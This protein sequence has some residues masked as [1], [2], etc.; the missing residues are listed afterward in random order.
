MSSAALKDDEV[1][2][3]VE[4]IGDTERGCSGSND[5]GAKLLNDKEAALMSK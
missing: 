4:S 3:E 1:Y 2:D 5:K